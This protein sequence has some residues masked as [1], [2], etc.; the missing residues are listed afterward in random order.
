LVS[1]AG[2]NSSARAVKMVSVITICKMET[3]AIRIQQFFWR[4]L[5]G[6]VRPSVG[7]F[8][9]HVTHPIVLCSYCI[10]KQDETIT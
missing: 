5:K 2:R 3:S 7:V 10:R 1:L 8:C 9:L 6:R 4:R